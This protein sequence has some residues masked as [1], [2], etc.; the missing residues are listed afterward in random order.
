MKRWD[1]SWNCQAGP[2]WPGA[3]CVSFYQ[4]RPLC[5]PDNRPRCGIR[6]RFQIWLLRAHHS[7]TARVFLR[8]Y[9]Q[10]REPLPTS[11]GLWK[12]FAP[13]PPV[14]KPCRCGPGNCPQW[15]TARFRPPFPGPIHQRVPWSVCDQGPNAPPWAAPPQALSV[16]RAGQPWGPSVLSGFRSPASCFGLPGI[17]V[18]LDPGKTVQ[19]LPAWPAPWTAPSRPWPVGRR[20]L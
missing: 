12:G 15:R 17:S 13:P 10:A 4:P 8:D 5:G 6:L 1:G 19:S 20:F 16:P 18:L 3:R 7:E 9:R 2:Q 14:P 11:A